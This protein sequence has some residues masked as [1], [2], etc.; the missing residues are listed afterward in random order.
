MRGVNTARRLSQPAEQDVQSTDRPAPRSRARPGITTPSLI[1]PLRRAV[2]GLHG[3][4]C[5]RSGRKC[6]RDYHT[7]SGRSHAIPAPFTGRVRGPAR[8]HGT[9]Q[10]G[11]CSSP[12]EFVV[13]SCGE[14]GR[15]EHLAHLL[16]AE[17]E[18]VDGPH[19][20]ELDH[21]HL[22]TAGD[23]RRCERAGGFP[24][25]VRQHTPSSP[26]AAA[27]DRP[28]KV[29]LALRQGPGSLR[30]PTPHYTS[31]YTHAH[32]HRHVVACGLI[33]LVSRLFGRPQQLQ[34]VFLIAGSGARALN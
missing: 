3:K 28:V 34:H 17:A 22:G 26:P 27:P 24:Q 6:R 13:G 8:R 25:A 16:P 23:G 12:F 20:A 9:V 5:S 32:R 19:V 11:G 14:G 29:T 10:Y 15:F 2:P 18:V 1:A 21:F 31:A 4:D 33:T 7:E 30:H